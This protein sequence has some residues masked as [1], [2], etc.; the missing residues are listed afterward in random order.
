MKRSL[1]DCQVPMKD[2]MFIKLVNDI[3]G[4]IQYLYTQGTTLC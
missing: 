2:H 3:I 4:K 1:V